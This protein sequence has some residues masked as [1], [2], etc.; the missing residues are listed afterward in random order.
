MPTY[1]ILTEK[2]KTWV[3]KNIYKND[4]SF[5]T[6]QN[7]IV[8]NNDFE[9]Y[10][11]KP[12]ETFKTV[13]KDNFMGMTDKDSLNELEFECQTDKL[14]SNK[15]L[16]AVCNKTKDFQRIDLN[17]PEGIYD[18]KFISNTNSIFDGS[19]PLKLTISNKKTASTNEEKN[20]IFTEKNQYVEIKNVK[21]NQISLFLQNIDIDITELKF[22]INF[23]LIKKNIVEEKTIEF[24]DIDFDCDT[25]TLNISED[26]PGKEI[27]LRNL[28]NIYQIQQF[29]SP[30]ELTFTAID[31]DKSSNPFAF[32]FSINEPDLK[33]IEIP[34]S[35][36]DEPLQ[37]NGKSIVIVKDSQTYKFRFLSGKYIHCIKFI[38]LTKDVN[39]LPII[40]VRKIQRKIKEDI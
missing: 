37:K 38:P 21:L 5:K 15:I 28:N 8:V 17:N 20:F 4:D 40:K 35:I 12:V 27:T 1:Q 23:I 13:Y 29:D 3:K 18:I 24:K 33:R 31:I 2:A 19:T 30:I 25:S 22:Q 36:Y 26:D 7:K 39:Y 9:I 6:N 16:F 10:S 34:S 11:Q 14:P 32:L